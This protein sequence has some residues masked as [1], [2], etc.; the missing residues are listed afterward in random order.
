[1]RELV[2]IILASLCAA[3][4]TSERPTSNHEQKPLTQ[5]EHVPG[6]NHATYGPVPVEEQIF[7]IEYLEIAPLPIPTYDLP[8]P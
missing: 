4:T 1:M 5:V 2:F 8:K 6:S 7:W 3:Y